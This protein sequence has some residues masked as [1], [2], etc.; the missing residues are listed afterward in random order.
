MKNKKGFTL[1]EMIAVLVI[2]LLLFGISFTAISNI[3]NNTNK[4]IDEA[5][6]ELI[7]SAVNDYLD[8]N[9]NIL[10]I[11][12]GNTYCFK[13]GDLVNAGYLND[14]QLNEIKKSD[15]AKTIIDKEKIKITIE[16]T[17][18]ESSNSIK[19]LLNGNYNVTH[20]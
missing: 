5:T 15:F 4:K 12:D 19:F 8:D 10:G 1:I 3:L 13:V 16:T 7:T 9:G 14:K 17:C 18:N 2:L 20:I 11:K 6:R